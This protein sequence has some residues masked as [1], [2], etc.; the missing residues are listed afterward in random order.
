MTLFLAGVRDESEVEIAIANGA[1]LL[2]LVDPAMRA[3]GP[4]PEL[5]KAL[6]QAVAG[7]RSICAL[8]GD[9]ASTLEQLVRIAGELVEAGVDHV[10]VALEPD[11]GRLERIAALSAL[12]SRVKLIGVLFAETRLPFELIHSLAE[13]G[14]HGAMLDTTPKPGPRLL[15]ICDLAV[16]SRFVDAA[17]QKG[18]P[19]WL[20]GGLEPPDIPRLLPLR[21]DVLGF[22]GALSLGGDRG[23][24]MDPKAVAMMRD[25]IAPDAERC[26]RPA[27][28]G[29]SVDFRLLGGRMP[30]GEARDEICPPDRIFVRDLVLPVRVGAYRSEHQGPQRV[31][32]SVEAHVARKVREPADMRDI[33]SYDLITDSIRRIVADAHFELVE[34]LAERI[35][36]RILGEPRVVRAVI[37][38]EKLD[39][40][41]GSVGVEITRD[42][43]GNCAALRHPRPA[44]GNENRSGL[45]SQ[46]EAK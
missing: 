19:A 34:M 27:L 44:A 6:V 28:E 33:L 23:A 18:M 16:L 36:E 26:E 45:E 37:R 24:R 46:G 17:R 14:F 41:P 29:A 25:L 40:G 38:V 35:A 15:E 11:A 1:D 12:A 20:S 22:R 7:R 31:R 8:A 4:A 21:P 10:R 32:F 3:R 30:G 43:P 42:R 9:A 39:T 5:A 13:A 2:D